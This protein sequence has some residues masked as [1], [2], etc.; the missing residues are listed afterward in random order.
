MLNLLDGDGEAGGA[1]R[2]ESDAFA[3]SDG[4]HEEGAAEGCTL[5]KDKGGDCGSI[6]SGQPV[7]SSCQCTD[8]AFHL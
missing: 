5:C 3:V 7:D 1:V 6:G 4:R 8:H 2:P